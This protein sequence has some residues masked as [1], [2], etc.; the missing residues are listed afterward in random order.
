[1]TNLIMD[2]CCNHLNIKELIVRMIE[3]AAQNGATYV[4]F[5]LFNAD[6]LNPE[7]PNYEAQ[8]AIMRSMMLS[9][10]TIYAILEECEAQL[11]KPMF[12][13]FTEDRIDFL[14]GAV[15]AYY[16]GAYSGS[17]AIKIASPDLSSIDFVTKVLDAFKYQD[18]FISTG[19]HTKEEVDKYVGLYK[20]KNKEVKILYC[21]SKYPTLP[22]DIDI[23]AALAVDGFSDHTIGISQTKDI[24]RLVKDFDTYYIEKHFTLSRSL[25]GKDQVVSIEP[26]ELLQLKQEIDYYR[27]SDNYKKRWIH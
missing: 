15:S 27:N 26:R 17:Y 18:V 23:S 6:K 25:P 13:I 21:V 9:K 7:Y 20:S 1:M 10:K 16:K 14:K 12:T 22:E 19:M 5:Q 24:V 8:K 3:A 4:K 2:C 11:I